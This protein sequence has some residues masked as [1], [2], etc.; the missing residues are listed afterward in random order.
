MPKYNKYKPVGWKNESVRHSLASKGIKTRINF[1]KDSSLIDFG[2]PYPVKGKQVKLD[3]PKDKQKKL[4]DKVDY[5]N[6]VSYSPPIII[7]DD[8]ETKPAPVIYS[9]EHIA[10]MTPEEIHVLPPE[11]KK[12]VLESG[13]VS[14]GIKAE[15]H[16]LSA[17]GRGAGKVA[18]GFISTVGE[19]LAWNPEDK[20]ETD[21]AK[22]I[23]RRAYF[24]DYKKRPEVYKKILAYN[25]EYINRPK[26]KKQR[27]EHK[28]EYTQR[29]IVKSKRK[30]YI[31]NYMKNYRKNPVN[32]EKERVRRREYQKT[33]Q[34]KAKAKKSLERYMKKEGVKVR[35]KEWQRDY[36]A[37]PEIVEETRKY[38]RNYFNKKG[39]R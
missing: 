19:G 21:F 1:S 22:G 26:V 34:A 18:K 28:K 37:T 2:I 36:K 30:E 9:E 32:L 17:V 10:Q 3:V 38:N 29:P 8:L 20:R 25:R 35:V 23:D 5:Q 13:W 15:V 4:K 6:D 39:G 24:R 31:K 11:E 7:L 14:R 27:A 33:P 12:K 16:A